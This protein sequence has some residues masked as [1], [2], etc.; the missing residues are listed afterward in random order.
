VGGLFTVG[1]GPLQQWE[2]RSA[3]YC[4]RLD[5]YSGGVLEARHLAPA[6]HVGGT[7]ISELGAVVP[8]PSGFFTTGPLR[9]RYAEGRFSTGLSPEESALVSVPFDAIAARGD[10]LARIGP[11]GLTLFDAALHPTA[12]LRWG[13]SDSNLGLSFTPSGRVR[14]LRSGAVLDV[15]EAG[16]EIGRWKI[17]DRGVEWSP[18]SARGPESITF[19]GEAVWWRMEDTLIRFADG[20]FTLFVAPPPHPNAVTSSEEGEA[21]HGTPP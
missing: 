3:G 20:S 14:A 11:D 6:A 2:K 9:I 17:P 21:L 12:E 15:D 10:R 19:A 8:S 7:L 5:V 13:E 16:Q 4:A 1:R 18:I